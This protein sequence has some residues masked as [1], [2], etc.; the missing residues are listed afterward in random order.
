[1]SFPLTFAE[2]VTPFLS[3]Y[4]VMVTKDLTVDTMKKYQGFFVKYI[5]KTQPQTYG[6]YKK[7]NIKMVP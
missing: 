2:V 1:M 3:D 5:L 6:K 4:A 7:S